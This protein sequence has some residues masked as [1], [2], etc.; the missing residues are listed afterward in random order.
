MAAEVLFSRQGSVAEAIERRVEATRN[1]LD[2]A[3][4]RLNSFRLATLLRA[5]CEHG[6]RVR[7][8][9]DRNK[10]EE[11]SSMR[12]LVA[13]YRLPFRVAWGQQGQGSKMHHKFVILDAHTVLTGS[14]NWTLES[15]E[16]NFENLVVLREPPLVEA[17][18]REFEALWA[19]AVEAPSG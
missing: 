2:G 5:C 6:V 18:R 4:Y 10:Y 11:S 17:Y 1:S 19:E 3:L 16:Q 8:V 13:E 12:R 7:L 14:Y 15:E 9:L